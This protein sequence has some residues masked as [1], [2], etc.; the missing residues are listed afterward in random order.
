MSRIEAVVNTAAGGV[1]RD[2][3]DVLKTL[4]AKSGAEVRISACAPKDVEGALKAAIDAAPDLLVVLAGDGTAR[5]AAEM[6]GMDG[7]PIAPLAGGTMNMLPHAIYGARPWAEALRETLEHG[8]E[9]TLAGGDIDGRRF[10]VAAI[11][12]A[13]ALWAPAREAAREG[14]AREALAHALAALD[15]SFAG[16]LRYSLDGGPRSETEALILMCPTASRVMDDTAQ[17]LEAEALNIHGAG[18]A[19]RLGAAAL[20]GDWRMDPAVEGRACQV[21][22]IWADGGAPALVDGELVRLS[23]LTEARFEPAVCRVIAPPK[24]KAG[25]IAQLRARAP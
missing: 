21:A 23:Q 8:T 20:V 14:K 16:R 3:P 25:F 6:A 1:A 9:K 10:L 4:L 18:E 24:P 12:G 7:P 19:L 15:K 22:N 2:A 5:A 17:A 13:P 11:V